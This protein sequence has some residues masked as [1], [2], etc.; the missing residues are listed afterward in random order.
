MLKNDKLRGSINRIYYAMFYMLLALALKYEFDTSKHGQLIGW[1]NKTFIKDK[2]IDH[3]FGK[4]LREAFDFR[5]Q[6]DYGT[7]TV[8]AK[9]DVENKFELMNEFIV[10]IE[11]F[12]IE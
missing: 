10:H 9:K 11:R 2:I 8:I 7:Y 5:Q 6:G 12:I 3:R 1:F 4:I